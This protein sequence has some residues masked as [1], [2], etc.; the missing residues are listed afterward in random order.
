MKKLLNICTVGI[1]LSLSACS[2][3]TSD[4]RFPLLPQSQLEQQSYAVAYDST[5]QTYRDRVNNSYDIESFIRGTDDWYR[6][7]IKLP[8]EQIRASLLNRMLDHN[9]YAYYSGVLFAADLQRNFNQLSPQCWS[10]VQTPSLTQGIYTAMRDLQANKVRSED[11]YII[12]GQEKFL[13]QCVE[14]IKK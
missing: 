11:R 9:V 8:V 1:V 2:F 6:R 14:A 12:E 5:I 4:N 7:K 13:Q 10:K 3:R